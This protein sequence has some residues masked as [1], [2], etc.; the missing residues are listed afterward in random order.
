MTNTFQAMSLSVGRALPWLSIATQ[1]NAQN[2]CKQDTNFI[3][4]LSSKEEQSSEE[5]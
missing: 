4:Y 3:K 2:V 1:R 5:I